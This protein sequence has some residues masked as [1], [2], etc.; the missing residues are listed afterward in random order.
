MLPTRAV[1]K[2]VL[3]TERSAC[4]IIRVAFE[5]V[6]LMGT[7]SESAEVTEAVFVIVPVVA[8]VVL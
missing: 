3:V 7:E 4:G 1:A 5:A 2:A 6:L 8:P